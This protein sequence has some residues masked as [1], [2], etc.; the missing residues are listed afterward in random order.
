MQNESM[1]FYKDLT[2]RTVESVKRLGELNLRTFETLAAKQVEMVQ[3]CVE[4][5]VK[6]SEVLTSNGGDIKEL[7][8]AQAELSSSC[9]E[10]F[11]NN[12]METVDII[13]TAQEELSGLVEESVAEVK[14][15][16]AKVTEISK[17]SVEEAV[18]AAKPAR[19]AKKAA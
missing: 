2:T 14:E 18:Q 7:L 15:N 8:S 9:A 16:V 13:K 10:Q 12:M 6:Q 5:G 19:P 4:A 1:D 11:T 17:K 3:S